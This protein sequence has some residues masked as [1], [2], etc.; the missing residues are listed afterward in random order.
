MEMKMIDWLIH[1]PVLLGLMTVVL[2]LGDWLLTVAQEKARVAH[3]AEHYQ[4]YPINTIEGN[5]AFQGGIRKQQVLHS[6]Q[7]IAAM[8]V[9]IGIAYAIPKI[10][11]GWREAWL[12][13]VWGL[14]LLVCTQYVSNLIG[15]GAGRRGI[16]GKVWMHQRTGL[17]I[18]AGRYFSTTL[19]LLML[20]LLSAS[21]VM[22]GVTIAGFT[23]GMRQYLWM[24]K[25]PGLKE[26][27]SPPM[28]EN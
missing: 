8:V 24:R 16:H 1:Y 6:K 28:E 22:Y 13:Y 14:F 11:P 10:S 21:P 15:Y 18:Q 25:V 3:Y 26:D 5:P 17:M 7:F 2:M 19:L 27:D 23:S 4:S 9:G 20:S 12:G